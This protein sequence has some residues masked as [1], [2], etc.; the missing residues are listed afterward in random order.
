MWRARAL[1]S[2]Y[3]TNYPISAH[4]KEN[5]YIKE[6][7]YFFKLTEIRIRLRAFGATSDRD[8]ALR[9]SDSISNSLRES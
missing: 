4:I 6:Y 9:A 5:K 2:C 3:V 7:I 1:L 8:S